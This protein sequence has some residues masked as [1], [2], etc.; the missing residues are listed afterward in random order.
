MNKSIK[1]SGL[2]YSK[3]SPVNK[4]QQGGLTM[5]YGYN[6]PNKDMY[7]NINNSHLFKE[8][9]KN[10]ITPKFGNNWNSGDFST[11]NKGLGGDTPSKNFSS[12]IYNAPNNSFGNGLMYQV[13]KKGLSNTAEK[14]VSVVDG[15]SKTVDSANKMAGAASL[16]GTANSV[17]QPALAGLDDKDPLTY[18]PKEAIG[19]IA[20]STLGTAAAGMSTSLALSSMA[21]GA[22]AG[23]AGFPVLGTVIGG[24]VGLG[25]GLLKSGKKKREARKARAARDRS[26]RAKNDAETR[27][28]NAKRDSYIVGSAGITNPGIE[29]NSTKKI[30]SPGGYLSI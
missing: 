16:A 3:K 28:L 24:L 1:N 7:R 5:N 13:P 14:A 10:K 20:G 6:D 26:F 4:F 17:I 9:L 29:P 15:A 23:T 21:A 30:G 8:G 25:I 11:V 19:T 27:S 2:F 18:K 22:A 12:N